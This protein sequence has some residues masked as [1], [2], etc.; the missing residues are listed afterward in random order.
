MNKRL[1]RDMEM[2]NVLSLWKNQI[3]FL[4]YSDVNAQPF[5]PH[6]IVK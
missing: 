1:Y 6:G 3:D 2:E 4:I 5:R